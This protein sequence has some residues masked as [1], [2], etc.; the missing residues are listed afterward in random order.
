MTDARPTRSRTAR[1]VGAG[2]VVAGALAALLWSL[3]LATVGRLF[4]AV[5][6]P[7]WRGRRRPARPLAEGR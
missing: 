5:R 2:V 7:R 6:G 3:W 1:A 4:A